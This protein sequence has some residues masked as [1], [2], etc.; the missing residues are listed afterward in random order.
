MIPLI[1]NKYHILHARPFS[2]S[3]N[4]FGRTQT[5]EQCSKKIKKRTQNIEDKHECCRFLSY[6]SV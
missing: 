2:L 6:L 1:I 4:Y 3:F 5:P